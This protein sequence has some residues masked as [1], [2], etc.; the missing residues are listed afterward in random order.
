[1]KVLPVKDKTEQICNMVQEC[2]M[3]YI[4]PLTLL[5]A[6]AC[7]KLIDLQQQAQRGQIAMKGGQVESRP[8][9]Q[10]PGGPFSN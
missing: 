6:I 9:P 2:H 4:L 10:V 3:C 7:K 5:F 1:M 8:D